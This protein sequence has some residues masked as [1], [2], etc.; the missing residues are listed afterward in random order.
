MKSGWT[1]TQPNRVTEGKLTVYRL[2]W[3]LRIQA[4][5][6]IDHKRLPKEYAEF[7]AGVGVMPAPSSAG[8]TGPPTQRATW[9]R[10]SCHDLVR[11]TNKPVIQFK[12]GKTDHI[13]EIAREDVYETV[14]FQATQPKPESKW[15]ASFYYSKWVND[16][17]EFAYKKHGERPSWEP[18]L[19]TFFP[20][21][22]ETAEQSSRK[23]RGPRNFLNEIEEVKNILWEAVTRFSMD[24]ATGD[25]APT[26]ERMGTLANNEDAA[27]PLADG[28]T[29]V[30]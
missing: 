30:R 13:L 7:E 6:I 2:D 27:Q 23:L 28:H 11:V 15:T 16:L 5:E 21:A 19:S 22:D 4:Y 20:E 12:L 25:R 1:I 29:R 17:G 3:Q 9:P 8:I 26:S 10:G 24:S 14:M 18:S